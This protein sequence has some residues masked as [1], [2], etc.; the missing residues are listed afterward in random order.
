[1]K[2]Y[3]GTDIRSDLSKQASKQASTGNESKS[4]MKKIARSVQSTHR[5]GY[6][7]PDLERPNLERPNLERKRNVYV[8]HSTVLYC[9]VLEYIQSVPF[10]TLYNYVYTK[11]TSQQL[12]Y[13]L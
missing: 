2:I 10:L 5:T 4:V 12:N 1:V 9:A 11:Y 13:L 7:I 6:G 8:L 3:L